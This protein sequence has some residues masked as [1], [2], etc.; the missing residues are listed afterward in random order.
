MGE[1]GLFGL[2]RRMQEGAQRIASGSVAT[3]R[4]GS[5]VG[6]HGVTSGAARMQDSDARSVERDAGGGGAANRVAGGAGAGTVS[7]VDRLQAQRDALADKK[8]GNVA[9]KGGTHGR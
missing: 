3:D 6:G 7:A 8:S 9:P 4:A 2:L 1:M 5:V